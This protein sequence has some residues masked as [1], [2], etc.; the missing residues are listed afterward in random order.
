[1][2]KHETV[3]TTAIGVMKPRTQDRSWVGVEPV[4]SVR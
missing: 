4:L 2:T 1:M 3:D